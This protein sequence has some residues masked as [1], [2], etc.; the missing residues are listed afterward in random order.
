[1][2][3]LLGTNYTKQKCPYTQERPNKLGFSHH[4]SQNFQLQP[5]IS[6]QQLK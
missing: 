2:A 6:M 4:E 1:V 3:F 5:N